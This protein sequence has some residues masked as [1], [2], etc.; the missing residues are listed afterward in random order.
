MC[1]W[2]SADGPTPWCRRRCSPARRQTPPETLRRLVR[3]VLEHQQGTLQ[4][5]ATLVLLEWA[6]DSQA[7][8]PRE[9]AVQAS[10]TYGGSAA[11]DIP[12][13]PSGFRVTCRVQAGVRQDGGE[14]RT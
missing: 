11:S 6:G 12:Q 7:V 10:V 9:Q 5:D 8:L 3:A 2:A 4:D 13:E 1:R 14:R